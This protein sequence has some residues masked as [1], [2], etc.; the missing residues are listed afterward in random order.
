MPGCFLED[1]AQRRDEGVDAAAEI[2]QVDQQD[3]EPV[4][5]RC[6][7]APYVAVQAVHGN[8]ERGVDVLRRLD[9]VVLLVAAQAVL[10][11]ERG[12]ETHAIEGGE[13]IERMGQVAGDGGGVCQQ[14]D[15][16]P[17]QRRLQ[18]ALREQAIEAEADHAPGAAGPNTPSPSGASSGRTK[19][20]R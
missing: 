15:A 14:G 2:L 17:G 6:G 7:R 10:R 3:V 12:H 4:H 5:H 8:A 16:P 13:G 18:V 11:P 19:P 1:V 9:H 20:S